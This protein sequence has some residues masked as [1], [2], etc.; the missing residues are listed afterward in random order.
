MKYAERLWMVI[1]M[2]A[3]LLLWTGCQ[4]TPVHGDEQAEAST[5]EEGLFETVKEVFA[6]EEETLPAG[7][8]I[9]VRLT[10]TISTDTDQSGDE[11]TATLDSALTA[12]N[13]TLATKDAKVIGELPLVKDSRKVKGRA[14]MQ[15]TLSELIVDGAEYSLETHP[16]TIRAEGS[17]KKDAAVIAGSAAAGA[18][19]GALTGGGKGAAI[20]AGVGGGAGTGFV[21]TTKGKEVEFA[22]ETLFVF[23]LSDDLTLPVLERSGS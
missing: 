6:G 20:G 5:Q 12:N 23:T 17:T 11:F 14:Q 1:T 19:I 3:L 16:L 4:D 22:P 2:M 7:T 8:E 21:L 18:V 9:R 15:L 13:K 10:Q